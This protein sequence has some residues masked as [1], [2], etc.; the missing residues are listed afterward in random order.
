[1]DILGDTYHKK[2]NMIKIPV[3]AKKRP[4]SYVVIIEELLFHINLNLLYFI[5]KFITKFVCNICSFEIL[6]VTSKMDLISG[7]KVLVIVSQIIKQKN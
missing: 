7:R 3:G 5:V 1:M 6:Y 2:G 4:L